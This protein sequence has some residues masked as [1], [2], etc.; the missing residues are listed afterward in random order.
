MKPVVKVSSIV[1][2]VGA[3]AL[4][5]GL[6]G[7]G[8][9]VGANFVD[10]ATAKSN[11]SVGTFKCDLTSTDTGVTFSPNGHSATVTLAEIDSSSPGHETAP[12][13][14]NNDGTIPL[15]VNWTVS[16]SGALFTSGSGAMG[17]V[18]AAQ[19]VH[20]APGNAHTY[21]IGFQ[22]GSLS[23]P[24]LGKSGTV[25]YTA[26]CTEPGS[27]TPLGISLFG[28]D[29]GIASW[30][31]TNQDVV[32][33]LPA[34]SPA[35]AGAGILVTHPGS[36][37]PANQPA[38]ITDAYNAGSP[39]WV[40]EFSDHTYAFGYFPVSSSSFWNLPGSG[41]NA[42]WGDVQTYA[43]GH[44]LTVASAFI[45]MDTD[46][47]PPSTSHISCADYTGTPFFGTGC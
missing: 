21:N 14:V 33:N 20:V 38:L 19:N 45:V 35:S 39:R 36:S 9:G 5:L 27:A 7:F 4:G 42:T 32:L 13:T 2:A 16:T 37:L 41:A 25:T 43:S 18:P 17:Y 46:Q 11:V 6:I 29:G 28:Q 15:V 34:G 10:Q 8:T 40:I 12:L 24:D 3:G 47:A 22:W 26:N 30:D 1:A 31:A 44:S 23:N